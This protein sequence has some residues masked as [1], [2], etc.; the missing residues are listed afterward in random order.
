M[1]ESHESS[2]KNYHN[3][4][5][6]GH[7]HDSDDAGPTQGTL[8]EERLTENPFDSEGSRIL[9]NAIDQ[10]QS[11]DAGR[12]IDIPQLVIV[13]GQSVG[14]SSLLQSLVD[15][16]FPT[17]QGCCTRFA[18]RIVS[19]RTSPGTR[20]ECLITIV[21]PDCDLNEY[22]NYDG[23]DNHES[24]RHHS[25]NLGA[26][27]FLRIMRDV[28]EKYMGIKPG[29][30]RGAKNFATE[31]LKIELSGPN[32][33]HFSILDI[34]GLIANDSD[35]N[36]AEM[37]GLNKMVVE[38]L[39]RP[40]NIVIC[41]A[42]ASYD[43]ANQGVFTLAGKHV[44]DSR[45]LRVFTKCDNVTQPALLQEVVRVAT[46]PRGLG[47]ASS[48]YHGWFVVRNKHPDDDPDFD[49]AAA[50]KGLFGKGLW[51]NIDESRRGSTMLKGYLG[52]LLCARIRQEF[53]S[54]HQKVRDLL[55]ET[56]MARQSLGKPR[57]THND[58]VQYLSG[59]VQEFQQAAQQAL[60]SPGRLPLKEMRIRGLVATNNLK[61]DGKMRQQGH[62]Y[63][64]EDI[65]NSSETAN[66]ES[67]II[68]SDS[69]PLQARDE[70]M[71]PTPEASPSPKP[72]KIKPL[73]RV[74]KYPAPP[75]NEVSEIRQEIRDQIQIYQSN[76]LPGLL[77]IEIVP[78][79][80]RTQTQKWLKM[81]THHLHAVARDM[82]IATTSIMTYIDQ[83][84]HVCPTA[85]EGFFS[86]IQQFHTSAHERAE[87]ALKDYIEKEKH[88]QLQT[89]N[90][91]FVQMLESLR[92]E[93]VQGAFRDQKAYLRQWL[94]T[95]DPAIT[96]D[97]VME[98]IDIVLRD[99]H[100]DPATRMEN[101]IHDVLK[102]HYQLELQRFIDFTTKRVIED[103]VSS[104]SGPLLGLSTEYILSLSEPEIEDLAREDDATLSRREKYDEKIARLTES[105]AI[106]EHAWKQTTPR[107]GE[108]LAVA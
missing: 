84:Y 49:L 34:P 72:R 94:D 52:N 100:Y 65:P 80:Y 56:L 73:R 20:N 61:F 71:P 1:S 24:F 108:L 17:G 60:H 88:Y 95:K 12:D 87:D 51:N 16:P 39:S 63:T 93:R 98:R 37:E 9:F 22:F 48:V 106:V 10:L 90:P 97:I 38:Y 7:S 19:R 59:I 101:D 29:K 41:V 89:T 57:P 30:G 21:K 13:G 55:K 77:N 67:N 44:E 54:L 69:Q 70:N 6:S 31:V 58:R 15:I 42:D 5:R 75:A 102:V 86:T 36:A 68:Q 104:K 3:D 26:Q 46:K 76:G 8:P 96:V 53:P 43:L 107:Q 91:A 23:N 14:K 66:G 35:V 81:A 32:R 78:E 105:C 103:F 33:S 92:M 27:E 62:Q 99:L 50:E 79:L 83:K 18:T 28:E 4:S 82:N 45:L 2:G 85:L 64:F 47:E 40:Q 11:C 74:A 25:E